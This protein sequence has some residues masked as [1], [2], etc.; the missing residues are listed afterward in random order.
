MLVP[1]NDGTIRMCVDSR[2]VNKIIIKYMSCLENWV[3]E[4]GKGVNF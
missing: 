3:R 1:K 4:I 2:V